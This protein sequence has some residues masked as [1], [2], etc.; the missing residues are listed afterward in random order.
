MVGCR[1][2][3]SSFSSTLSARAAGVEVIWSEDASAERASAPSTP[4]GAT[5]PSPPA[6]SPPGAA[7]VLA[8]ILESRRSSAI[9]RKPR[10]RSLPHS[11]AASCAAGAP[12]SRPSSPSPSSS[13]PLLSSL[14]LCSSSVKAI[15]PRSSER[16]ELP[17]PSL[18]S[19]HD[20]SVF[21]TE[22]AKVIQGSVEETVFIA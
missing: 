12:A 5:S 11:P 8:A 1:R 22:V 19:C 9:G 2:L 15:S 14:P 17:L 10:L 7:A 13:L 6:C 3:S 16:T 21:P 20:A 18:L 4:P